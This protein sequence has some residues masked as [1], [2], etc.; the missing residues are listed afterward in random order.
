MSDLFCHEYSKTWQGFAQGKSLGFATACRLDSNSFLASRVKHQYIGL[1]CIVLF[2]KYMSHC[3]YWRIYMKRMRLAFL[4]FIRSRLAVSKCGT[5]RIC[6]GYCHMSPLSLAGLH[7]VD[8][9]CYIVTI[10]ELCTGGFVIIDYTL[11]R[12]PVGAIWYIK[13]FRMN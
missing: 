13:H 11:L 6:E 12:W 5:R 7:H 2:R 3:F 10:H 1:R 8:P 4:C 9:K